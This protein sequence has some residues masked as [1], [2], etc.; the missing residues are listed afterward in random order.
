[1]VLTPVRSS[2]YAVYFSMLIAFPVASTVTVVELRWSE[3]SQVIAS[4]ARRAMRRRN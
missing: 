3:S 4:S 2:P 1:V